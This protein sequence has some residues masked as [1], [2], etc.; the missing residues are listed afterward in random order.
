[1]NSPETTGAVDRAV[2]TLILLLVLALAHFVGLD[3]DLLKLLASV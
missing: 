3:A 2:A 1:L